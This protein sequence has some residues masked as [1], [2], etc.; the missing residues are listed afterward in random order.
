MTLGASKES[1]TTS[2]LYQC[3]EDLLKEMDEV[4]G[5]DALMACGGLEKLSPNK[6]FASGQANE[7]NETT[8]INRKP[9]VA[10]P[11]KVKR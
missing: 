10:L 11:W 4:G 7:T 5:P 9:H 8:G 3:Q 6:S 2:S 1:I